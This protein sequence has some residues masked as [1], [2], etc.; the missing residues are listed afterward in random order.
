ML[1]HLHPNVVILEVRTNYLWDVEPEVVGSSIE[2]LVTLLLDAFSVS[3]VG[4]C[5]VILRGVSFTNWEEFLQRAEI[6]NNYICIVLAPFPKLSV[7]LT[8]IFLVPIRIC[9]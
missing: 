2:E 6:L 4:V 7:G 9:I 5:H 8:G 3:V 1:K